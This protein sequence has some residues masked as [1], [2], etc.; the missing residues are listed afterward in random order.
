MYIYV[1]HMS[2]TMN[3]YYFG[4][5]HN[6]FFFVIGAHYVYCEVETELLYSYI[7]QMNIRLPRQ[8]NILQHSHFH[9]SCS[10]S[11]VRNVQNLLSCNNRAYSLHEHMW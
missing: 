4:I 11:C 9:K 6:R 2:F 8:I 1:F 10:V 7:V 5:Q 3:G